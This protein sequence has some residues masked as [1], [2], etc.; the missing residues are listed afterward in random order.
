M[1]KIVLPRWK[2]NGQFH[3]N[4][5]TSEDKNCSPVTESAFRGPKSS[6]ED[7]N[8]MDDI[9]EITRPSRRNWRD[10]FA[11]RRKCLTLED[12]FWVHFGRLSATQRFFALLKSIFYRMH[13][14][15]VIFG[16]FSGLILAFTRVWG[17]IS[18][19]NS[20]FSGKRL[21]AKKS[22]LFGNID[23]DPCLRQK[24][25]KNEARNDQIILTTSFDWNHSYLYFA[26]TA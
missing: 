8:W 14:D 2:L 17:S 13:D 16:L 24:L 1:T 12:N 26:E 18:S 22:A 3:Q 5:L 15:L 9:V 25:S 11:F 4:K 20:G 19:K 21:N 23:S 6:S 7:E 10:V